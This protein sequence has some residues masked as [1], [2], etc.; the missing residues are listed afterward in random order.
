MNKNILKIKLT[1]HSVN[2]ETYKLS[3]LL[4]IEIPGAVHKS[5]QK[6]KFLVIA[7]MYSVT[8][9][10]CTR[11]SCLLH[12]CNHRISHINKTS[13]NWFTV[14]IYSEYFIKIKKWDKF[15][16]FSNSFNNQSIS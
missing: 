2:N 15:I 3:F 1:D 4:N 7:K 10:K 6:S 9:C 13:L 11:H 14:F 12:H 16:R 5:N 8:T